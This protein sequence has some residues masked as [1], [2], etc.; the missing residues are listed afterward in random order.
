MLEN[1]AEAESEGIVLEQDV[2]Y[3]NNPPRI[4]PIAP[5]ICGP[6]CAVLHPKKDKGALFVFLWK[7]PRRGNT[8]TNWNFVRVCAF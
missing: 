4:R 1:H 8:R 2:P 3:G 7:Q 6:V 5:K